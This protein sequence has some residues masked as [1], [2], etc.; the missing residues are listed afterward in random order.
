[1]DKVRLEFGESPFINAKP[2]GEMGDFAGVQNGHQVHPTT[3]LEVLV[4][5]SLEFD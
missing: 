1:L 3:A 4:A 2:P 5:V